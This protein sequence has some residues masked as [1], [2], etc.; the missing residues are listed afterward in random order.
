LTA[1]TFFLAGL[2]MLAPAVSDRGKRYTLGYAVSTML[3]GT[4]APWAGYGSAGL[5]A[6]GWL[7][8]GGLSTAVIMAWQLRGGGGHVA[9]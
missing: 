9:G 5:L 2:F 1:A 8:L 4:I 7:V 3:A 6:G